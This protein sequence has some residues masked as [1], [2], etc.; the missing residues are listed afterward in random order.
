MRKA[1]PVFIVFC[2][3]G[4]LVLVAPRDGDTP[5][6]LGRQLEPRSTTAAADREPNRRSSKE[7]EVGHHPQ[8]ST[9]PVEALDVARA[10]AGIATMG[11]ALEVAAAEWQMEVDMQAFWELVLRDVFDEAL[12]DEDPF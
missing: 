8:E 7:P 12:S 4:F 9:A 3:A 10:A 11:D 1:V 6:P 2:L 5:D